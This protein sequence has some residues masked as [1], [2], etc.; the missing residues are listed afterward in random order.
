MFCIPLRKVEPC[1]PREKNLLDGYMTTGV[2]GG[3]QTSISK[4]FLDTNFEV[5][6][7]NGDGKISKHELRRLPDLCRIDHSFRT[8]L[9]FLR[10]SEYISE[11]AHVQKKIMIMKSTKNDVKIQAKTSKKNGSVCQASFTSL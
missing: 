7:S 5:L 11:F 9:Y 10:K 3:G 8:A 6:D 1:P 2:L 4:N